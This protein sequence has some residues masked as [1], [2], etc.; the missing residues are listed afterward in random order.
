MKDVKINKLKK[1]L[2]DDVD[3]P[4]VM[5]NEAF[6]LF[7]K[8]WSAAQKSSPLDRKDMDD[9]ILEALDEAIPDKK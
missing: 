5:L 4:Y 1:K 3:A 7:N 9:L 6:D 2:M 8:K